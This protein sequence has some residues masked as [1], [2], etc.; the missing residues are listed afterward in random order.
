MDEMLERL[1]EIEKRVKRLEIKSEMKIVDP[2]KG[3]FTVCNRD[4]LVYLSNPE[5]FK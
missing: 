3:F 2:E 5:D 4:D 1:K